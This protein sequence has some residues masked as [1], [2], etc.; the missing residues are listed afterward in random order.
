[1]IRLSSRVSSL[2]STRGATS[3]RRP[4]RC[5]F[6]AGPP[7]I[8]PTPGFTSQGRGQASR[9]CGAAPGCD[10][11]PP[12]ASG[13][14]D[15]GVNR[16]RARF[17]TVAADR[18]AHARRR[19][20]LA[21]GPSEQRREE[22]CCLESGPSPAAALPSLGSP[23]ALPRSGLGGAAKR[24][25]G[26]LAVGDNSPNPFP[27]FQPSRSFPRPLAPSV[28]RLLHPGFLSRPSSLSLLDAPSLPP[29]PL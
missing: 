21:R 16:Q 11:P 12:L 14:R 29:P 26:L 27:F 1:M 4:N 5:C 20:P 18:L 6:V 8:T 10:R 22:A 28:H 13:W 19:R 3:S 17:P 2:D 7:R 25:A 15:T 9:A 24:S 23:T